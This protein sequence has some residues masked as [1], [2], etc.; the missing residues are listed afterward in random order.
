MSQV[1]RPVSVRT[2]DRDEW[3]IHRQVRLTALEANPEAF[4]ATLVSQQLLD[5]ADWRRRVDDRS[6][7][8]F[9]DTEPV[10]MVRLWYDPCTKP[11]PE[12]I[13]LW[14]APP[15]R[16]AGVARQLMLTAV[17][18]AQRLAGCADLWVS[19]D[20]TAARGLYQSLGF[21]PTGS[22]Q[23]TSDGRP[24]MHMRLPRR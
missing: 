6:W 10:G 21:K 17:G 7:F 19:L 1:S 23:S 12:V 14:V 20:N 2:L 22:T 4:G 5:E 11:V 18:T 8:A 9:L 15:A 3:A 24:E 13:A 16:R